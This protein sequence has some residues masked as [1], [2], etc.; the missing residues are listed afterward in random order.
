MTHTAVTANKKISLATLKKFI[1]ANQAK[2]LH[3]K[4]SVTGTGTVRPR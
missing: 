1:R 4:K 3:F 2:G